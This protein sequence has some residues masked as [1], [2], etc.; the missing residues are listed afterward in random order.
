MKQS[1]WFTF[2]RYSIRD[3]VFGLEDGLVSTVGVLTGIAS[4]TDDHFI[5]ILS[6]IVL[7]MVEALSMGVGSFLSAQ[8][9]REL[10][11]RQRDDIERLVSEHP[12]QAQKQLVTAYQELG[13]SAT[14]VKPWLAT[15]GKK[16][17][18]FGRELA[19]H[20]VGPVFKTEQNTIINGICMF[21]SYIL[22]GAVPVLPYFVLPVSVAIFWSVPLTVAALFLVGAVKG[23]IVH[24]NWWYS[25]LQMALVSCTAALMGYLI[26]KLVA[27]LW[28][29]PVV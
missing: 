15:L 16:P 4:G 7:I 28:G 2:L 5:V 24:K 20:Q 3:I 14:M 18:S 29:V 19:M 10:Q 12:E 8:S 26:G 6:G 11:S 17:K 22:G 9:E 1:S 13:L 23:K 25:G 27:H 21:F